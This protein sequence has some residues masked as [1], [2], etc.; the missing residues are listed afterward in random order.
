M[1]F[2]ILKMVFLKKSFFKQK[3]RFHVIYEIIWLNQFFLPVI[4]TLK[5]DFLG[6]VFRKT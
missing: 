2:S 3:V 5:S 1:K 4:Y 6:F